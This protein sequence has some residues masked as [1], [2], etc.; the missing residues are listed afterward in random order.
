MNVHVKLV[1]NTYSSVIHDLP[2]LAET[3][4]TAFSEGVAG[5]THFGTSRWW[6]ITRR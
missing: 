6:N 4:Q 1:V 5:G 2:K 3:V